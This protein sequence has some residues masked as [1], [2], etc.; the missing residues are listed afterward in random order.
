MKK[1]VLMIVGAV[2]AIAT[3]A[4]VSVQAMPQAQVDETPS[5]MIDQHPQPEPT[6]VLAS[7]ERQTVIAEAVVVP[8]FHVSLSLSASGTVSDLL[9]QEGDEIAEGQPLLS[10]QDAHQRAAVAQAEAALAG[11]NAGLAALE[12]GPRDPEIAFAVANRD[13]AQARL[14]R[15]LDG[16]RLL[17]IT[18]AEDSLAASQ[19]ALQRLY[20]GPDTHTLIASEAELANAEAALRQAQAAYDKVKGN[21]N[22]AMLPQSLQL[23]Q[24]TNQYEAVKA[25]H[26]AL[27]DAPTAD[28]VAA[29]TARVSQAMATV[30][31]LKQPAR[32][33]DIGEAEAL[34]SGA[35]AQLDL[36]LAGPRQEELAAARAT[37]AGAEAALLQAKASLEDTILRSPAAGTLASLLVEKGEPVLAGQPIAEL[38]DL[39][40][41]QIE[42]SD[43]TELDVV[44][45]K[46]GDRVLLTFDAISD[47]E[48]G[49]TVT[50]IKPIGRKVLGDVTYVAVV[51]PDVQDARLRWNMTA[52]VT[53]R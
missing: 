42:T 18:A 26:D 33:N 17:D 35:Q 4:V 27:N 34:T 11:A 30:E 46:E 44:G 36:L 32:A 37:V 48:L 28:V 21:E 2:L 19:A 25:H 7:T 5:V 41:W 50:Q 1:T 12:A 10:V 23:Q 51:Q 9:V 6:E 8:V 53:V 47:L 43:L 22:I 24:A 38:A 14:A 52:V 20:D 39:T 13:A 29:A 45:V 49:G 15:L 3:V 31:R 40:A 16:S